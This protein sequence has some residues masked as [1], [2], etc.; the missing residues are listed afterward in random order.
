MTPEQTTPPAAS[1]AAPATSPMA[2]YPVRISIDMPAS[3]SRIIALF[4]LPFFLL[5]VLLLIP[6]LIILYV[7]SIVAF[8]AAWINFWVVLFTGHSSSGLHHFIAGT[9]RWNTR[10]N[11]YIYGLN[12]K[13]PPFSMN[14]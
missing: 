9:M 1:P 12:D 13:Y 11:G 5:R 4:S 10:V 14:P 2:D 7:L 8:L 6:H 3:Q